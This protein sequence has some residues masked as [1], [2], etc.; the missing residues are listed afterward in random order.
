MCSRTRPCRYKHHNTHVRDAAALEAQLQQKQLPPCVRVCRHDVLSWRKTRRNESA[1]TPQ[2]QL[3][4]YAPHA[5]PTV[6]LVAR[7]ATTTPLISSHSLTGARMHNTAQ[8]HGMGW[9]V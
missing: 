1:G 5:R 8:Q 9:G 7:V 6:V 3:A 2:Q 4:G